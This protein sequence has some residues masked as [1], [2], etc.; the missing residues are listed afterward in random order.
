MKTKNLKTDLLIVIGSL[1]RGGCELHLA[2][3]LPVL[4]EKGLNISLFVTNYCGSL[5]RELKDAGINII[6]PI[7][8]RTPGTKLNILLRYLRIL[9][10]QLQFI[11]IL[12][13][14]KPNI[15]HFFLPS[16][17][18]LCAPPSLLFKNIKKVMSR[19]SLNNYM[20]HRKMSRTIEH[21][22]HKKMDALIGN[23][24]AVRQQLIE[25]G[26]EEHKTK[27]IYSGVEIKKIDSKNVSYKIDRPLTF[28]CVANLIPYKGHLDLIK[29]CEIFSELTNK[30][31]KLLL[32]GRD[33][34]HG[35]ELKALA[36]DLKISAQIEFLGS[37]KDVGTILLE[38]DIFILPS[39]EEGLPNSVLEAMS[40][41]LPPIVTNVGGNKDLV[42]NHYNGLVVPPKS[43]EDLAIAMLELANSESL[44]K[45][46]GERSQAIIENR[47]S[48]EKC[49]DSYFDLYGKLTTKIDAL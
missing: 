21:F 41:G 30:E 31:W 32:A 39:H 2:R 34:G 40:Y 29:A 49:T 46:Y 19:R 16:S 33:D 37:V 44:R 23:S 38:S 7:A 25:E 42:E 24:I 35:R 12:L 11:F 48:L 47:F 9:L 5:E 1:E 45:E 6:H 26:A 4:V 10:I 3:V 18:W 20:S 8:K 14:Q 36:A 43:P 15:I 28:S 22:L 13:K 27:I 17:Y